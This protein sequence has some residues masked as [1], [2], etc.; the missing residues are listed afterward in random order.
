MSTSTEN[1]IDDEQKLSIAEMEIIFS[2]VKRYI[3]LCWI[4][5]FFTYIYFFVLCIRPFL[6][7]L[8]KLSVKS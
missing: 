6:Q 2:L 4:F 8:L 5:I 3:I 7:R 1:I